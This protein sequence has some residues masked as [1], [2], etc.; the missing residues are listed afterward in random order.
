MYTIVLLLHIIIAVAIVLIVLLQVGKGSGMG[1][2]FG[3][4]SESFFG[5][6]GPSNFLEKATIVTGIIFLVTSL[7][8]AYISGSNGNGSL[9]N[10]MP[11]P[12][13][14]APAPSQNAMPVSPPTQK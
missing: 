14:S 7:V 1:A 11:I 2:V 3:G 13:A 6:T 10:K 5:S 8:L 4:S 12:A 9:F